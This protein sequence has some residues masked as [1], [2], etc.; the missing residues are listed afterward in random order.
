[1][2]N[3]RRRGD[4]WT[5]VIPWKCGNLTQNLKHRHNIA[6]LVCLFLEQWLEITDLGM[7]KEQGDFWVNFFF[8]RDLIKQYSFKVGQRQ[9]IK[10]QFH[11]SS[12]Y[13]TNEF[14][15][16]ISKALYTG[17]WMNH[18][19]LHHWWALS[20]M[21]TTSSPKLFEVLAGIQEIAPSISVSFPQRIFSAYI[22]SGRYSISLIHRNWDVF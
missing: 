20:K 3:E 10:F 2:R 7:R 8:S 11:K 9:Q 12:S 5:S 1:M 15:Q 19:Q 17:L 18:R 4:A 16:S 22:I 6:L 13:I 21:G 14:L